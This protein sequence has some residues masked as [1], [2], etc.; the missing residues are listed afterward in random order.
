MN[1]LLTPRSLPALCYFI[2]I[3]F[4]LA[5]TC[6]LYQPWAVLALCLGATVFAF[7]LLARCQ[8]KS[9]LLPLQ[10]SSMI[11]FL[12]ILVLFAVMAWQPNIL[13]PQSRLLYLYFQAALRGVGLLLILFF[14][15][16]MRRP[17]SEK[18]AFRWLVVLLCG[19]LYVRL[20]VLSISPTPFIDVYTSGSLGADYLLNGLNPYSQSYPDIYGG[21]YSYNNGFF[22]GPV[23][24][25]LITPFRLLHDIRLASI[26]ADAV[27]LAAIWRL[28]SHCRWNSLTRTVLIL[29]WLA[30]PVS[31]FVLEQSWVDPLMV[32]ALA[33]SFCFLL[34]KKIRTLGF[35]LGITCGIK[36]YGAVPAFFILL[37]LAQTCGFKTA[38]KAGFLAAGVFIGAQVPF[39]LLDAHAL[40]QSTWTNVLD[41]PPRPDALTLWA[42]IWS[43]FGLPP[44]KSGTLAVSGVLIILVAWKFWRSE[45]ALDNLTRALVLAF[46]ILFL[47]GYQAFCNYYYLLAFLVFLDLV[48]SLSPSD[49]D[50]Q[51][52]SELQ[53][54]K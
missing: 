26:A 16:Q 44:A 24:L 41:T 29:L 21:A 1:A 20:L 12:C 4:V 53:S 39:L 42:W 7:T 8:K 31:F 32:A 2:L 43:S 45:P 13:Y 11:F 36:H 48:F 19:F 18:S 33:W 17:L 50:V 25:Y 54:E 30:F 46:S 40:I 10:G 52:D 38:F 34:E 9:P 47:L 22:Y 28:G 23:Y 27:T 14:L 15:I 49:S 35:V 51:E 6:G 5:G 3:G 37:Y